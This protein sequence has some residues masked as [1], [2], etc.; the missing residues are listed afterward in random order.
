PL[1]AIDIK[2][3]ADFATLQ[4]AMI[5]LVPNRRLGFG[6]TLHY[7]VL[8]YFKQH[9]K[10]TARRVVDISTD[11]APQRQAVVNCLELRPQLEAQGTMVNALCI[12]A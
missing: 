10:T 11:E 8:Q 5:A 4:R 3:E 12:D 2:V 9:P 1:Y 6:S 7:A